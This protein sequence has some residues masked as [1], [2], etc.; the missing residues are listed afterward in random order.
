M[1]HLKCLEIAWPSIYEN[2]FWLA[3]TFYPVSYRGLLTYISIFFLSYKN[4][5]RRSHSS[6]Y[7]YIFCEILDTTEVGS[8]RDPNSQPSDLWVNHQAILH[9]SVAQFQHSSKHLLLTLECQHVDILT[10][11]ANNK[12]CDSCTTPLCSTNITPKCNTLCW[13]QLLFQIDYHITSQQT[14]TLVYSFSFFH[15]SRP[16]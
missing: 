8:R 11:N 12:K 13:C 14:S 10:T 5:N 9:R 16:E 7:N 3:I 6:F 4:L 15:T 2:V 1:S